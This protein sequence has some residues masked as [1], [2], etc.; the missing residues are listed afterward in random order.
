MREVDP[1]FLGSIRWGTINTHPALPPFNR[2]CHHSFWGIMEVTPL[3]AT[4]HW[5][6]QWQDRRFLVRAS[7]EPVSEA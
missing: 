6:D 5:M 7:I 2:G 1:A 3:G 4:L